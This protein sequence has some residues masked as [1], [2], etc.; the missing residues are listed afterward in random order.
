[1]R[2]L[3]SAKPPKRRPPCGVAQGLGLVEEFSRDGV[4]IGLGVEGG[5][6]VERNVEQGEGEENRG[7]SKVHET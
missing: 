2:G 7:S 5:H 6:G 3:Y 1:M 4:L